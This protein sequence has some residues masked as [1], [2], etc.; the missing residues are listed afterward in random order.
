VSVLITEA[1]RGEG[2]VLRLPD[3]TP[4]MHRY[5]ERAELAPRDIVSRAIVSEMRR[6]DIDHV[7][8]DISHQPAEM[9]RERFPNVLKACAAH[10]F[11][12][13]REPVP[14]VP[15]AHYTCGGIVV[16]AHGRTDI[17]QLYALGE[18]SFTGLHGANRLASNSL[19][20][21]LAFAD[22]ISRDIELSIGR[23]Q[24]AAE[25][26]TLEATP[27]ELPEQQESSAI[28]E[29]WVTR[30]RRSMWQHVGIVRTRSGLET[31]AA[32]L[33]AL[34]AEFE[35][36]PSTRRPGGAALEFR[37]MLTVAQLVT[38][39]AR[40]R[41]ESRGLH[42]NADYPSPLPDPRDTALQPF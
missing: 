40:E 38:R 37:N 29:S 8:L 35:N 17:G 6:L 31:A 32:E 9:I 15:A 12:L 26:S 27:V 28:V 7:M 14:V 11:D 42:F 24:A 22:T 25:R 5:D 34:E 18:C 23:P 19:L 16:D 4:F 36:S 10:G 33:D 1:V 39:S 30:L 21:A 20:E 2:G 13:T 3:G 41:H